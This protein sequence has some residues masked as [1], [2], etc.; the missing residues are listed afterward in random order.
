MQKLQLPTY[1]TARD[2]FISPEG[3]QKLLSTPRDAQYPHKDILWT[4]DFKA[5]MPIRMGKEGTSAIIPST[6]IE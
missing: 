4:D 3:L 2:Y 6:L 1:E 5:E